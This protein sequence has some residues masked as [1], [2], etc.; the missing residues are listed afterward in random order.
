MMAMILEREAEG[1]EENDSDGIIDGCDEEFCV[2][3]VLE[4]ETDIGKMIEDDGE[5]SDEECDDECGGEADDEKVFSDCP[6][7]GDFNDRIAEED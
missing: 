3:E 6:F 2:A 4:E 5:E 7:A 1:S